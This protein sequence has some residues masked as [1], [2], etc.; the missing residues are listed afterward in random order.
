MAYTYRSLPKGS[1][2]NWNTGGKVV[3]YGTHENIKPVGTMARFVPAPVIVP[4]NYPVEQE[5]LPP[6][7]A[8][9]APVQQ[10]PEEF[11]PTQPAPTRSLPPQAAAAALLGIPVPLALAA[12]RPS[13]NWTVPAPNTTVVGPEAYY[14][15]SPW[16]G[17]AQV[18]RTGKE[19]YLGP[20]P[21]GVVRR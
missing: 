15:D 20:L 14:P 18:N 11:R 7:Q 9:P 21:F 10:A 12:M 5:P 3:G 1:R 17:S 19:N 2:G 4:A 8:A 13:A 6:V 16:L